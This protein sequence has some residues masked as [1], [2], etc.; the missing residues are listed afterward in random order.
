M[1]HISQSQLL[2]LLTIQELSHQEDSVQQIHVAIAL[3]YSKASV[4]HAMHTLSDAG[5]LVIQGRKILLT[6]VGNTIVTEALQRYEQIL[7]LLC[8]HDFKQQEAQC[9]A[10][11]LLSIMDEPFLQH[12][13]RAH[14]KATG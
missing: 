13:Q 12:L 1:M 5:L 6:A 14:K 4:S 7:Q 2:Y 3:G 10:K 8:L 11:K 9:Y